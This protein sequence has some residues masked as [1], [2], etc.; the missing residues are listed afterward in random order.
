MSKKITGLTIKQDSV[1]AVT[2]TGNL[3]SL[4]IDTW[5]FIEFPRYDLNKED[6]P[7]KRFQ[8]LKKVIFDIITRNSLEDSVFSISLPPELFSHR[9]HRVPLKNRSKIAQILPFELEPSLIKPMNEYVLRFQ[10]F[11]SREVETGS[12]II[13]SLILGSEFQEY[14]KLFAQL[15][16]NVGMII[17]DIYSSYRA[18][19]SFKNFKD[20]VF[21]SIDQDQSTIALVI[22][23]EIAYIRSFPCRDTLESDIIASITA[24]SELSSTDFSSDTIYITGKNKQLTKDFMI[25]LD[26]KLG[27][28]IT[29]IDMVEET[30][31][32]EEESPGN[33]WEAGIFD[34]A[35]SLGLTLMTGRQRMNFTGGINPYQKLWSENRAGLIFMSVML[36]YMFVTFFISDYVSLKNKIQEIDSKTITLYQNT[37]KT[38]INP[39][40]VNTLP[41]L[42]ESKIRSLEK[43][44]AGGTKQSGIRTIDILAD[45]SN[46]IAKTIDV[47]FDRYTSNN[48]TLL[49]TGN[50]DTFTTIDTI[51]KSL[52]KISYFQMVELSSSSADKKKQRVNFKLKIIMK[53]S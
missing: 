18:Y 33:T 4:N 35:L 14:T 36:L 46:G 41:D 16:M 11:Q 10:Q 47:E 23:G 34:C 20:A 5:D 45:M 52:E 38:K 25:G 21:I 13:A 49:L 40:L 12:D 22:N 7:A 28:K 43:S 3:K 2:V 17:P 51:K 48:N 9:N 29:R 27:Q 42:M 24:L 19:S 32:L 37:F 15:G 1:T 50:T 6:G 8:K 44:T 53:D 30:G 39:N 26:Y 31:I